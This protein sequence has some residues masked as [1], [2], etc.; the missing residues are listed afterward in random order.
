MF[1]DTSWAN[2]DVLREG[3][4]G[5]GLRSQLK[6]A[7]LFLLVLEQTEAIS[8]SRQKLFNDFAVICLIPAF[9]LWSASRTEAKEDMFQWSRFLVLNQAEVLLLVGAVGI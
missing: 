5:I 7:D 4:L 6:S 1:M 9:H 3:T 2:T 8:S